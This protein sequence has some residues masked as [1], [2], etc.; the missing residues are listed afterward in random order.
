MTTLSTQTKSRLI[1]MHS[2]FSTE[3]VDWL[4]R[5]FLKWPILC[6]VGRKTWTQLINLSCPPQSD[7]LTELRF[8]VPIDTKIGHFGY[9]LLSQQLS[10]LLKKLKLTQQNQIC[11][12]KPE[13][14]TNT[15]YIKF[16]VCWPRNTSSLKMDRTCSQG[17]HRALLCRRKWACPYVRWA[18]FGSTG[19][20]LVQ[21]HFRMQETSAET[22]FYRDD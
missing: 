4:G 7:W 18:L 16:Q 10:L 9:V 22:N 17:L 6:R 19:A 1:I 15:K 11:I 5:T 13:Y 8:N 3:P 2:L 14:T 20:A 21:M 12:N